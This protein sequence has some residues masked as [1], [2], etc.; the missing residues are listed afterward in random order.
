MNLIFNLVI[1]LLVLGVLN[2]F[3]Y[4]NMPKLMGGPAASN[5][6]GGN[7]NAASNGNAARGRHKGREK[8]RFSFKMAARRLSG[9]ASAEGKTTQGQR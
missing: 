2:V 3:I 8:K 1:P 7:G 9:R 4:R 5:K 6:R